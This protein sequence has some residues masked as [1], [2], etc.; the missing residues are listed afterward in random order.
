MTRKPLHAEGYKIYT[1]EGE[2]VLQVAKPQMA[3]AIEWFDDLTIHNQKSLIKSKRKDEK[4]MKQLEQS[5]IRI[6]SDLVECFNLVY[7]PDEI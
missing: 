1:K 4:E 6:A 3:D 5:R 7:F 2:Y